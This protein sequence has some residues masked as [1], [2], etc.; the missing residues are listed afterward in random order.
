MI[1]YKKKMKEGKKMKRAI[2]QNNYRGSAYLGTVINNFDGEYMSRT[3]G[4][5]EVYMSLVEY[6]NDRGK[7]I[8]LL[9]TPVMM[10]VDEKIAFINDGGYI[11]VEN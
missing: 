11:Y 4:I 2:K 10:Q 7:H 9:A 5:G 8:R 3:V 1:Y 6:E